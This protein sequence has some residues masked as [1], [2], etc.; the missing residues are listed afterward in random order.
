MPENSAVA[1]VECLYFTHRSDD[2]VHVGTSIALPALLVTEFVPL[3]E[4]GRA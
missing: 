3:H 2:V 1:A 4:L